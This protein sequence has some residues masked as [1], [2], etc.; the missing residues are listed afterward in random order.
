MTTYARPQTDGAVAPMAG[1]GEPVK[2]ACAL[3]Q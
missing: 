1:V 2:T 3:A